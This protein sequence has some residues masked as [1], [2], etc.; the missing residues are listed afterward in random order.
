MLN[1]FVMACSA[2]FRP[3][4]ELAYKCATFAET[5]RAIVTIR[6][7]KAKNYLG[8]LEITKSICSGL[9]V[10]IDADYFLKRALE[11]DEVCVTNAISAVRDPGVVFDLIPLKRDAARFNFPVDTYCNT[12]FFAWDAGNPLHQEAFDLALKLATKVP[13]RELVDFGEQTYLNA[14]WHKLGVKRKYLPPS[15]NFFVSEPILSL[16]RL[17]G[18]TIENAVGIHLAGFNGVDGKMAKLK[19]LVKAG[20]LPA[21]QLDKRGNVEPKTA[22]PG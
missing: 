18:C 13:I 20:H 15:Y 6:E 3:I 16:Q 12:G 9:A 10:F 5:P 2:N 11:N 7:L 22:S 19:E 1:H 4:A 14:A 21:L 8:K 17:K